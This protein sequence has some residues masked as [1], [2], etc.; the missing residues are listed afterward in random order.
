MIAK[1]MNKSKIKILNLME[2]TC[3]SSKNFELRAKI[4]IDSKKL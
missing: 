4:F 1:V 2:K 3:S